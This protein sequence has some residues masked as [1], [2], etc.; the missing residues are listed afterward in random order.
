MNRISK[1][2]YILFFL[3]IY[4]Y[5][6][7][8]ACAQTYDFPKDTTTK[9]GSIVAIENIIEKDVIDLVHQVM[10]WATP[11]RFKHPILADS[12]KQDSDKVFFAFLPA[13]GYALQT[14]VTGI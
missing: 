2:G 6:P 12:T 13:V 8:K 3:L 4:T 1:L 5:L 14:G 9:I 10:R 11:Q 7:P